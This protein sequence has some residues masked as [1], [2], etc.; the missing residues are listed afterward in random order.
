MLRYIAKR[1]IQTWIVLIGV[2]LVT[3][4]LLNIIPGDPVSVMM[5]GRA[6]AETIERIK[7][8]MGFNE[9]LHIQYLT[10][11][12][13]LV[14]GNL[15]NS[16]STKMPV[17]TMISDSFKLT[18]RLG[19]YGL[20]LG[21]GLGIPIGI[22]A[23]INRGNLIDKSL[24]FFA[25]LGISIPAFW[26]AIV[27]QILFGLKIGILPISGID[28]PYSFILPTITLGSRYVASF[29]RITRTSMLEV[30]DSDYMKTAKAK[31]IS[32]KKIILKHGFTNALIPIVTFLGLSIKGVLGGA[33]L[34]ETVF[35]IPG[36]GRLMVGA[37]MSRDIPLIQ[38]CTVYI[39]SIFVIINLIID[40]SYGLIDPR[41][42]LSKGV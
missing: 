40:L 9:P 19:L 2:T 16:F 13:G 23:A 6:D 21:M 30:L 25:M 3:F 22:I 12:K 34:I 42:S 41:V 20:I 8:E 14:T 27:L 28:S 11:L 17:K 37:I 32:S 10:F 24:M 1:L 36:I 15:G 35:S 38:G 33:I 4:T 7:E 39:A 29:S 31:G 5:E 18:A 26:V